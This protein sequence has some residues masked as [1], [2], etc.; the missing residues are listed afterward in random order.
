M[1][2]RMTETGTI[3]GVYGIDIP[4]VVK[5]RNGFEQGARYANPD[6]NILGSYTDSFTDPARGADVA[7][8]LIGD[9]ADVIFGAGGQ[10]GSGGIQFATSEGV[11]AIGVDND[12]Y[13]S[14]FGGGE[15]PGSEFLISSALKSVDV[16]AYDMLDALSAGNVM[17]PGG[18]IYILQASNGG[19][20]FAPAHDAD[21][22]QEVTDEV[23]MVFE[24]LA[25]GELETGVDPLTGELIDMDE[26]DSE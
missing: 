10:T 7:Q 3:G 1:A 20:G 4:P 17:W 15:S 19:V 18:D 22:P 6:I 13:F 24:M 26:M 9:G 25:A 14:T 2:A 8:A 5:F 12:E 21:V 23:N 16:G 11:F